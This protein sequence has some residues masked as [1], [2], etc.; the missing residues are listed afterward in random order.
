ML[1]NVNSLNSAI[2]HSRCKQVSKISASQALQYCV[3]IHYYTSFFWSGLSKS[4]FKD[5]CMQSMS[6]GSL[7]KCNQTNSNKH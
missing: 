7:D 3:T 6:N 1:E 2:N 5:N 4:D